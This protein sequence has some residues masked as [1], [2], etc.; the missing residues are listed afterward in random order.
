MVDL[1][2]G[3]NYTMYHKQSTNKLDATYVDNKEDNNIIL[4]GF[5]YKVDEEEFNVY[6]SK[7]EF[8][9]LDTCPECG[10]EMK[11][12][13]GKPL[14]PERCK[15]CGNWSIWVNEERENEPT[16]EELIDNLKSNLTLDIALIDLTKEELLTIIDGYTNTTINER[17]YY[18]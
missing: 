6:W 5:N 4:Y 7:D 18:I 1:K 14:I 12:E 15:N 10:Y 13:L 17:L 9:I 8:D 2:I 11:I 3:K 16:R